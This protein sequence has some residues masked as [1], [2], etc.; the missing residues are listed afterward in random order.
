M[1]LK[2][3][4]E[5]VPENMNDYYVAG[6][7]A[8]EGKFVLSVES[9]D[10]FGLE[11][12]GGLKKTMNDWKDKANTSRTKLDSFGEYTP[13][14]IADLALKAQSAGDPNEAIESLKAEY[15]GKLTTSQSTI[16]QLQAT[17]KANAKSNTVNNIFASN[18]TS[19]QDGS[20]DLVK[21]IMAEY[22]GT[23]DNG[24]A[25]IFNEDKTGA[26]MSGK[27][28]A[29]E[30][31]MSPNEWLEGVKGAI[32]SNGSFDGIKPNHLKSMGFLLAS[33]AKHGSGATSPKAPNAGMTKERWATMDLTARTAHV[34]NGG[35]VPK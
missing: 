20:S 3:I 19:F 15:S 18:A 9:V 32:T 5:E 11:D 25:F 17:I 33:N 34:K 4:V 27:Q 26:R 24:N 2:A 13:E 29:W 30:K 22:I 1:P 12:V 28:G 6:E 10:G 23:D 7:G 35:S 21:Q 14:S 8:N 31:Q 16:E